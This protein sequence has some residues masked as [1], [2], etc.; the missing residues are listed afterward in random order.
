LGYSDL[1]FSLL[2]AHNRVLESVKF[3]KTIS[4]GDIIIQVL[5]KQRGKCGNNGNGGQ[6]SGDAD[7]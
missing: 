6:F 4:W 2:L 5:E 7:H 3:I 1:G